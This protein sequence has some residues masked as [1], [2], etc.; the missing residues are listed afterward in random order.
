[1][2]EE[3]LPLFLDN[4]HVA[5]VLN[6]TVDAANRLMRRDG[7]PSFQISP[8]RR[9]VRRDEFLAWVEKESAGVDKP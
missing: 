5:K 3:N 2:N 7:F 4:E 8:R 6:I 1:M 9:R